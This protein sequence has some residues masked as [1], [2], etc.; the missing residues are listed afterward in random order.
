MDNP[1][2]QSTFGMRHRT[3]TNK[4]K[5]TAQKYK[6]VDFFFMFIEYQKK[7]T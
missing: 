7:Q 1:N 4:T 6:I 2:T 5:H 3:R